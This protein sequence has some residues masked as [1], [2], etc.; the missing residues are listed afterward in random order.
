MPPLLLYDVIRNRAKLL[1]LT[2]DKMTKEVMIEAV[3][4]ERRLELALEGTHETRTHLPVAF[5]FHSKVIQL[6][7]ILPED[8]IQR[9]QMMD[10]DRP[11]SWLPP[12][13]CEVLGF[14]QYQEKG[15]GGS[16][17]QLTNDPANANRSA[18]ELESCRS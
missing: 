1:N 10:L 12:C 6:L 13:P 4:H 15:E 7:T 5:T 8:W 2:A 17:S 14:I 11:S 9:H 16:L 3:L 18:T